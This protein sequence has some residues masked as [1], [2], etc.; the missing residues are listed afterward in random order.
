MTGSL[1]GTVRDT[2][3]KPIS[4][5]VVSIAS[6]SRHAFADSLGQYHFD[7][8][9]V[10]R[11]EIMA[12]G[13]GF[14]TAM[15]DTAIVGG[16]QLRMD[17]VLRAVE[18]GVIPATVQATGSAVGVVR[19]TAG[20]PIGSYAFVIA[21]SS[22]HNRGARADSIGEYRIDSVPLGAVRISARRLGYHT[23]WVDTTITSPGEQLRADF[24]LHV[25]TVRLAPMT[26]DGRINHS[27]HR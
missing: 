7:A 25:S 3:G 8:V 18:S 27:H 22:G 12:W 17:F 19:D 26:E 16:R 6:A 2:G 20:H 4:Q 10:G 13:Y 5:A 14:R 24:E 15:V 23:T 21:T 11:V 1:I 9:P